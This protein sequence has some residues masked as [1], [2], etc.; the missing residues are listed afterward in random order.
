LNGKIQRNGQTVIGSGRYQSTKIL[1]G[2]QLRVYRWTWY[3]KTQW[4]RLEPWHQPFGIWRI[5]PL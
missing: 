5:K 2:P 1:T 3:G 4:M